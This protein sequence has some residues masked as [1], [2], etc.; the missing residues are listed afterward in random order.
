MRFN[1]RV[2]L[3]A[4]KLFHPEIGDLQHPTAVDDTVGRFQIA[5]RF[6]VFSV[7]VLHPF[8]DVVK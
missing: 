5:V 8:N 1:I 3:F 2:V 7:K 6:D 4:L